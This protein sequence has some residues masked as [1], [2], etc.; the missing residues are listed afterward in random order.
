MLRESAHA[1]LGYVV[2]GEEE[3]S[4]ARLYERGAL[5]AIGNQFGSLLD[6]DPEER[7]VQQFIEGNPILLQQFSP[8]RIY[9]QVPILTKHKT[10]FAILSN[11]G[12]LV[13][14]EIEK[15]GKRLL[16][17]DGGI[18]A[19]LQHAFDQVRDW[20]HKIEEHRA[21]TLACINLK[22]E[23]VV[24]VRGVVIAGRD[25]DYKVDHLRKLKWTDFGPVTFYTYDDLLRALVT[26]IR[27]VGE[28]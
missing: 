6:R 18:T 8:E 10:D 2:P 7:Q 1:L 24:S 28:L 5:E 17:K 13:L 19:G 16:K 9:R 23:E 26:L 3:I 27:T 11:K 21:A 25:R 14:I 15:P 4:F 12:E 22:P 20:L